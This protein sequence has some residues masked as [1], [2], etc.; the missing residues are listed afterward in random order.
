V[1][2]RKMHLE[3]NLCG[4]EFRDEIRQRTSRYALEDCG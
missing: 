3:K 2:I 1:D 4:K